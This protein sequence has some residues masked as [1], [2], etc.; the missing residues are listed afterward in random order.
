MLR[1]VFSANL[2]TREVVS[3]SSMTTLVYIS[4]SSHGVKLPSAV[5]W[6]RPSS[7]LVP[8]CLG[9][10]VSNMAMICSTEVPLATS[11]GVTSRMT[12]PAIWDI[13]QGQA[14]KK[15][16][17]RGVSPACLLLLLVEKKEGGVRYFRWRLA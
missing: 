5:R 6:T 17:G 13:V 1:L 2:P 16:R 8:T 12:L 11:M 7:S 14:C 3:Q 9:G 10:G 15:K 4:G